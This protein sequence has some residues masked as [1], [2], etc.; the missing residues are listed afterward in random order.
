MIDFGEGELGKYY[1]PVGRK[2]ERKIGFGF[3]FK[4]IKKGNNP[5]CAHRVQFFLR[6]LPGIYLCS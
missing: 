1:L 3:F 5:V 4:K 2:L 6:C